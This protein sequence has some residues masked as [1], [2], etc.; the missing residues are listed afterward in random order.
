VAQSQ[1]ILPGAATTYLG[2]AVGQRRY[3]LVDEIGS[4]PRTLDPRLDLY[5]DS[6]TGFSWG[7]EIQG[8]QQLA[9]AILCDYLHDE[10]EALRLA[11]RFQE[12]VIA[13]L[14][15]DLWRL[16]VGQVGEAVFRIR[17]WQ[18]PVISRITQ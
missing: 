18:A 8:S 10:Q 14:P 2:F 12:F 16:T 4:Y 9:V 11:K 3:V 1:A 15:V 13:Q 6:G 5:G 17:A 7:P